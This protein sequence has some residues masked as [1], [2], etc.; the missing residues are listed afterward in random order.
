MYTY[1][2]VEVKIHVFVTSGQVG[3][4]WSSF[5]RKGG[6]VGSRTGVDDME[7]RKILPLPGLEF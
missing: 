3:G 2:A 6:W 5:R 4:E 1:G 7:R